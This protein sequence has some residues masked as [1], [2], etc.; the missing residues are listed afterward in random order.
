GDD[1]LDAA[2]DADP[3]DDACADGELR[4][5]RR[6][7][8]ELEE[9]RV[10]IEEQLDA[11]PRQEL[12]A[13]A[14]PAHV[15]L[16]APR[17]GERELL[18][19]EPDLLEH[20]RVIHAIRLGAGVDAGREDGHQMPSIFA[21]TCFITSSAPPPIAASRESTKARAAGFSQQ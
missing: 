2:H 5:P 7:R 4:P 9:G 8:G 10:A 15:F 21:T 3:R 16:A 18:V 12:P 11:L 20:G 1:A 6:E 14:V 17:A 13:L 19:E